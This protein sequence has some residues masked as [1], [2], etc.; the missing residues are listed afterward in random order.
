MYQGR[1]VEEGTAADVLNAP[2]EAYTKTLLDAVPK[3]AV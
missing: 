3:L 2:Q 1:I